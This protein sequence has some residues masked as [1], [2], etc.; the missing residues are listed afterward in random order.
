MS[1][2]PPHWLKEELKSY[3]PPP[4]PLAPPPALVDALGR[5]ARPIGQSPDQ[6]RDKMREELAKGFEE[7]T[8]EVR[9]IFGLYIAVVTYATL[10]LAGVRD[11][12]FF[13]GSGVKLPFVDVQ[14]GASWFFLFMPLLAL[15]VTAYLHLYLGYARHFRRRFTQYDRPSDPE[16]PPFLYPWIG[17]LADQVGPFGALVR[18]VYRVLIWWAVPIVLFSYWARILFLRAGVRDFSAAHPLPPATI[19]GLLALLSIGMLVLWSSR[20][21]R[22]DRAF[23]WRGPSGNNSWLWRTL[24]WAVLLVTS[25]A[26]SANAGR[27]WCDHVQFDLLCV[28]NLEEAELSRR[29]PNGIPIGASLAHVN[30]AHAKL[31]GAF[32]E[33][34]HFEGANLEGADL[35]GALLTGAHFEGADLQHATLA[36]ARLE[37]AYFA[38][39]L[40]GA[41]WGSLGSLGAPSPSPTGHV[42]EGTHLL[43]GGA[44]LQ[45]A[46]FREAQMQGCFLEGVHLD[47]AHLVG[48]QLQGAQLAEAKLGEAHVTGAQLQGASL[49]AAG[50][51]GAQ[52]DRAQLQGAD[53]GSAD[54]EDASFQGA[55][56]E[57]ASLFV[58]E[59]S[60]GTRFARAQLQGS[61]LRCIHGTGASPPGVSHSICSNGHADLNDLNPERDAFL[62]AEFG[63]APSYCGGVPLVRGS[64]ETCAPTAML[65]DARRL[66]CEPVPGGGHF[67]DGECRAIRVTALRKLAMADRKIQTMLETPPPG[68]EW[69]RSVSAP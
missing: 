45:D 21:R 11:R 44:Q 59:I 20:R 42:L 61:D 49:Y 22:L 13:V 32:L 40:G 9:N 64:S 53:L 26:V 60:A 52:L 14:V 30:L 36:G 4:T 41:Y 66:A 46:N 6:A 31:H 17:T 1:S 39:P 37:G 48:A 35:S 43:D 62:F 3:P 18:I 47:R 63:D 2:N 33:A 29:G 38:E 10:A 58:A 68:L 16:S 54:L 50:L 23:N 19:V 7:T 27:P 24:P 8:K 15:G 56:L 69:V 12:D 67:D 5:P 51:R 57:G 34:A 55:N 65:T 28:A 25:L